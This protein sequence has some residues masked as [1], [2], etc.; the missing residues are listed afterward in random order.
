MKIICT[1]ILR[2]KVSTLSLTK[3]RLIFLVRFDDKVV[4]YFSGF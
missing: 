4:I 1:R 3:N 2:G